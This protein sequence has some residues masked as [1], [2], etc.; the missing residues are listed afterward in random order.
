VRSPAQ[1]STKFAALFQY[2]NPSRS[3]AA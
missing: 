2:F 3:H 1:T